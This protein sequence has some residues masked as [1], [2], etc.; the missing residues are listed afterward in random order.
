MKK[1]IFKI[2][3]LTLLSFFWINLSAQNSADFNK[4]ITK[5][6]QTLF[7][8]NNYYLDTVSNEK[9][10]DEAIKNVISELD[11]HSMYITAKDVKAMNEPLEGNFEG[12]GIEF[13]ILKDTLTVASPILGGPCEKVG[14]RAGDKIVKIDGKNIA[15]TGLT[16]EKV[17]KYLRGAKGTKA[18]LGIKRK[19]TGEILEFE[20]IRDKI[21]INSLDAAYEVEP[22]IVYMKL[23]RFA[24]TSAQ[25]IISAMATLKI[26]S[27]KGV[28]LD[29]RGNS[30]GFLGTALEITNFFLE[31]GQTIVYTEGMKVPKMEEKANGTGFYKKGPLTVLIDE[32]S[33]SA[34]EIVAGAIQ[35]WDR[36]VIIGRRSF[37]KGLVQQ[38]LPLNDGSQLRLT[39][40]RYHTP[41]GRVIQSPYEQGEP[42]K[43]YRALLE[44][45]NRGE[46]FSKDSIHFP[47]SLQFKTLLE[48]RTVFGGG[49]IMP[50][51]F[52]PA[53]TTNYTEYYG[54]L[55]RKGIL[56]DFMN[57]YSDSNRL[58]WKAEFSSFETFNKNYNVDKELIERLISYAKDRK[59]EPN[60]KEIEISA[61]EIS[62][63]IKAMVART[64]FGTGA[65]YKVVNSSDDVVFNKALEQ[66]KSKAGL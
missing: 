31:S 1:T 16:N 47:D 62:V 12:V 52:V 15:G 54:N 7:Y 18:N 48:E 63:N 40:A 30:G 53:D 6:G 39:I 27:I 65:Y 49:G 29:L 2:S 44:R 60:P 19:G 46:Y 25:E 66:I 41:S 5:F 3:L 4:L 28:I 21:P 57:D 36:G 32:N 56:L 11:P 17:Y 26:M 13:V 34:S 8:I 37:G 23:S 50:D 22:G 61:Q 43:Y 42:E 38:M 35:D 64:I 51:I 59:L 10:V 33:A 24:A 14:I 45:Y 20:V 58:K 55:L 9:M